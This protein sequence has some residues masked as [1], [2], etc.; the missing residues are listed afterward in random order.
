MNFPDHYL[1]NVALH[2]AVLSVAVFVAV[3]VMRKPQRIAVAALSGLLAIGILPWFSAWS[4]P[5]HPVEAMDTQPVRA[6]SGILPQW[7]VIRIPAIET[8]QVQMGIEPLKSRALPSTDMLLAYGWATGGMVL[9]LGLGI[10]SMR[11][12]VWRRSLQ[13][14]DEAAWHGIKAE[15]EGVPSR[16]S[17][18]VSSGTG[19]P[20]VAGF[21]HPLIVVPGYLME[22][23][24]ERE[25]RWAL[26][27]ELRHWRGGDSRWTTLLELIRAIHW[28]NPI[29]HLLISRWKIAREIICDLSAADEVQNRSIYGEFLIAMAARQ[30]PRNPLAVTMVRRQRLKAL[31]A[32]IVSVLEA[33]PGSG[34][35]FEKGVLFSACSALLGI[36]L[37][38]SGVRI[39]SELSSPGAGPIWSGIQ[40]D[41]FGGIALAED[42]PPRDAPEKVRQVKLETKVLFSAGELAEN[43]S[44]CTAGAMQLV[45]R[46][47]AQQ[48]GTNVMTFPAVTMRIG[49]RAMIEIIRE[50]PASPPWEPKVQDPRVRPE[51]YAGWNF[52]LGSRMEGE[53]L[54]LNANLGYGFVPGAHYAEDS[55]I[56]PTWQTGKSWLDEDANVAWDKL[57]HKQGV[58][59]GL[60]GPDESMAISLGEVTPGRYATVFVTVTPIDATGRPAPDFESAM[61]EVVPPIKGK[62]RVRGTVLGLAEGAEITS[63]S[64]KLPNLFSPISKEEWVTMKKAYAVK[65][66]LPEVILSTGEFSQPWEDIK[67]LSFSPGLLPE[68]TGTD[69]S[70]RFSETQDLPPEG[71]PTTG[72]ALPKDL[73]PLIRLR[74]DANGEQRLLLLEVEE[75]ERGTGK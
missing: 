65:K 64:E 9:L 45:M 41:P 63:I 34:T 46:R 57:V 14:V 58:A 23:G 69:L 67:G 43:G 22:G 36:A 60:L 53:K 49:E 33:A 3:L 59:T 61:Y 50:N 40:D 52:H 75:Q 39:G 71:A 68:S 19:S 5:E 24:K 42:E 21:F 44:V 48:K 25:L 4:P 11:V 55:P 7:T 13:P 56:L 74:P 70:F 54:K 30:S 27:H 38:I 32:R 35:P 73:M 47:L 18:R 51:G 1:F 8:R 12:V 15:L 2:A 10:A 29:V 31:R 17:F 72:I 26:R 6:A 20:C 62:V 28:W 16:E 66:E 37:V